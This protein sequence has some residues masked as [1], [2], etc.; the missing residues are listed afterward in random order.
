MARFPAITPALLCF[1]LLCFALLC[2]ALLC[3]ALLCGEIQ[4]KQPALLF[5]ITIQLTRKLNNGF[6]DDGGR[7]LSV[8]NQSTEFN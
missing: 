3:F 6:P 5:E 4:R 7:Y 1:A 8:R 2:F